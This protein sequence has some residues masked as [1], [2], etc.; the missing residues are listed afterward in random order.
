[1]SGP[2]RV[3]QYARKGSA[4]RRPLARPYDP[5][6]IYFEGCFG[7]FHPGSTARGVIL[8]SPIGPES[9]YIHRI[10]GEFAGR[11]AAAGVSVL[12]FD[13]RGTRDSQESP[14]PG[15]PVAAWVESVKAARRWMIDE[16]GIEDVALCGLRFGA[17]MALSCAEDL[18]DIER[19]V[20]LA[21]VGSGATYCR[22]LAMLAR[23]AHAEARLPDHVAAG[24][25]GLGLAPE[26]IADI[27]GLE[28]A[29][30]D[31][32][33]VRKA[34]VVARTGA[35]GERKLIERLTAQGVEV[36]EA[37]FDDYASLMTSPEFST[38]PEAT[39]GRVIE[40]LRP[41]R[42]GAR[43]QVPAHV[44]SHLKVTGGQETPVTFRDNA[45]LHGV[46]CKPRTP[47]PDRPAAL[48]LNTGA[49]NYAGMNG[50][51]VGM[52]RRLAQSGVASL[53]FDISGFGD[54]PARPDQL[55]P[56]VNMAEALGDV[57]TAME[58]LRAQG[59]T[60]II[61]IGFC[62]G[63]QLACNIA[64]TDD[65]VSAVMLVNPRRLFWDLE[66]P[67]LEPV[68]GLKGYMRLAREP[69]RWRALM[70]G[71]IPI[72][73]LAK[74]PMRLVRKA[75]EDTAAR[76]EGRE[77]QQEAAGRKLRSIA[78]RGVD[79]FVV[80]GQDDPFLA[81]FED[82]FGVP[83]TALPALFGMDMQFPH[84]V[85]HLFR[86]AQVRA[87]LFDVVAQR[88]TQPVRVKVSA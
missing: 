44:V 87:D 19:I 47:G 70:H 79:A 78:Q 50:L 5:V 22:E 54:S 62:W 55:D 4:P 12:R 57:D 73:K 30:G 32:P 67:P 1:V 46:F 66:T 84:G 68:V 82:Y 64:Q 35:A 20:L 11:L 2:S 17:A 88:V 29:T 43:A 25:G 49:I 9:D 6:Q 60:R 13:Y 71:D 48:L 15:H 8:C 18:K 7:W 37:A 59:H 80:Q 39:F 38:Y 33:A 40:W 27:R 69:A 63:A 56:F 31:A 23:V 65:R 76:A 51:W 53:R 81:E 28:L 58:W 83:R 42:A 52:A 16:A 61:L 34:L 21:P 10:W 85:D 3:L 77:T 75:F 14:D 86:T 45:P 24:D 72:A 74:V 26:I 41:Q 36:E